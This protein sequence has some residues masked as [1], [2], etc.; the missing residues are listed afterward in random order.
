MVPDEVIMLVNQVVGADHI[1]GT[2]RMGTD[3]ATSLVNLQGR[4]HDHPNLYLVGSGVFPTSGTANPTMT[5][6]ALAMWTGETIRG[7]L[8]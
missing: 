1:I 5:L 2:Y 8:G 6:A 4:T 3:P 7:E